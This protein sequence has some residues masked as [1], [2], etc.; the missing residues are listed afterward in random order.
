MAEWRSC[1]ERGHINEAYG[2]LTLIAYKYTLERQLTSLTM[3]E[4]GWMLGK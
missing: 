1:L 4:A 3:E 2:N